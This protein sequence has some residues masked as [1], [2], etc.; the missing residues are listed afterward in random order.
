MRF[1]WQRVVVKEYNTL[2]ISLALLVGLKVWSDYRA[3]DPC[4]VCRPEYLVV[5]ALAWLALYLI[6]RGLK[7]SGRLKG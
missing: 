5:S 4:G 1:N 2:F 7:K 3:N 6:V